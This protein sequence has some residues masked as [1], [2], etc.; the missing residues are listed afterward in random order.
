MTVAGREGERN[1]SVLQ[2]DEVLRVIETIQNLITPSQPS[3]TTTSA[4]LTPHPHN[5]NNSR[6]STVG[7]ARPSADSQMIIARTAKSGKRR[8]ED[9]DSSDDLPTVQKAL[10]GTPST[11]Q[12]NRPTEKK[13]KTALVGRTVPVGPVRHTGPTLNSKAKKKKGILSSFL[14]K[15]K[16][17]GKQAIT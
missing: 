3:R 2:D 8:F 15:G 11:V 6:L 17:K 12:E 4:S 16:G 9:S 14:S 1:S 5:Y 13:G 7:G 10:D